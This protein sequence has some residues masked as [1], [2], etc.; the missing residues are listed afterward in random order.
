MREFPISYSHVKW[1]LIFFAKRV[2]RSGRGVGCQKTTIIIIIIIILI[3]I[4]III[5]TLYVVLFL[6]ELVGSEEVPFNFIILPSTMRWEL[7]A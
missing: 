3:I 4:I 7:V 6:L 2:D 1:Y 5:I